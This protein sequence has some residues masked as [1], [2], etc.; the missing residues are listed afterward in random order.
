MQHDFGA[1]DSQLTK[2]INRVARASSACIKFRSHSQDQMDARGIDHD[3]VLTCLKRGKAHGPE[4]V[5]G[6]LR[7]NVIHRGM[8]VRVV[9]AG[10]SEVNGDWSELER[11]GRSDCN[12]EC[13]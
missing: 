4:H 2:A 13:K 7:A 11:V 1:F 6:E 3:D 8:H 10:L 9:V 5:Q 12:G